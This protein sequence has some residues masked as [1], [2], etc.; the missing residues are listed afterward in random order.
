MSYR[1]LNI[2]V[3]DGDLKVKLAKLY[4]FFLPIRMIYPFIFLQNIFVGAAF[5]FDFI[6][7]VLGLILMVLSNKGLFRFKND[8]STNLFQ[9]I[10]L[11]VTW[12]NISSLIMAFFIQNRYG[13]YGVESA[14]D[15]I[16]GNVLYFTQYVLM[17]I[18]N[19][20]I[21]KM[22]SKN[23]INRILGKVCT[24]LLI[25]GYIQ[26]I[27]FTLRGELISFYDKLDFLEILIS[28]KIMD[29]LPLT[30]SEGAMAGNLIAILI[31]PFLFS[32]IIYEKNSAKQIIQSLL[33]M[34]VIYYTYST[35]TYILVLINIIM[36]FLLIGLERRFRIRYS[37]LLI[38]IFIIFSLL[39]NL[40]IFDG[41]YNEVSSEIKYIL[42]EKITDTTNGSTALRVAPIYMNLGAFKEYP[43]LGVGNGNQGYFYFKYLPYWV[44]EANGSLNMINKTSEYLSN[45]ILFIPSLL[46]GY[47]IVGIL[48]ILFYVIK[49]EKMVNRNKEQLENF[50]YLYKISRVAFLVA[51]FQT[52]F[53]GNYYVWFVMSI[54]FMIQEQS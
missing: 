8:K 42:F 28:P 10:V 51:G 19:K 41:N 44:Y 25:L 5:Y 36:L 39:I 35:A 43:I 50:Y 23:E 13:N 7:H 4:I 34:P 14:F 27:V 18:Y 9:Y 54:P 29:K 45:G 12:F 22:L 2:T 15:G 38:S 1:N 49:S 52:L 47:G 21:F 17:I 24:Y 6:L 11:M 32:K 33:W 46:S 3:S 16:K 30:E 37:T 31:L 48:L 40:L 26:I 20:N 53:V